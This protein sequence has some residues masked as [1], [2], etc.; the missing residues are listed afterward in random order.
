MGNSPSWHL[1]RGLAPWCCLGAE[2]PFASRNQTPDWL[3]S[4]KRRWSSG[5]SRR[6]PFGRLRG[7]GDQGIL[8]GE[9]RTYLDIFHILQFFSQP[10]EMKNRKVN[11]THITQP[12]GVEMGR[13]FKATRPKNMQAIYWGGCLWAI[14]S[15]KE[16]RDFFAM[17]FI[18]EVGDFHLVATNWWRRRRRWW[19]WW[20][21]RKE[22]HWEIIMLIY[23]HEE[24]SPIGPRWWRPSSG[25]GWCPPAAAHWGL[26]LGLR[27]RQGVQL[28]GC[29]GKPWVVWE[30]P[31]SLWE[32]HK[33]IIGQP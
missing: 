4:L 10:S 24:D 26:R 14:Q 22:K 21:R 7:E 31:H 8:G 20:R 18:W 6:R 23:N 12:A 19:W 17:I 32:N 28:C 3:Q 30:I 33:I 5:R 11:S 1:Q 16:S 25:G 29:H 13:V 15:A 2:T 9:P 27:G